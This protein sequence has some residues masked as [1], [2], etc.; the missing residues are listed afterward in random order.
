M[1]LIFTVKIKRY[2]AYHHISEKLEISSDPLYVCPPSI[3]K[4]DIAFLKA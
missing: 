2:G 3:N 1:N 4:M